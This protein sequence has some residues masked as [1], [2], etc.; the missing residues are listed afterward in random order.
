MECKEVWSERG[1]ATHA[2]A[3]TSCLAEETLSFASPSDDAT[4]QSDAAE[5]CESVLPQTYHRRKQ[6]EKIPYFCC[7]DLLET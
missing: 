2:N 6:S 3:P 7:V 1:Q 5:K 4:G